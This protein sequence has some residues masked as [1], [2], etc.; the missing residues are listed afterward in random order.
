MA[1]THREG[2]REKYLW[3]ISELLD[4]IFSESMARARD[5]R[6]IA[7]Q[8]PRNAGRDIAFHISLA[9][10]PQRATG[11]GKERYEGPKNTPA[12]AEEKSVPYDCKQDG[13][14]PEPLN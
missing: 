1:K 14:R 4:R 7:P 5:E 2:A 9:F 3:I 6:Q 12:P 13:F 8:V 11:A 10:L